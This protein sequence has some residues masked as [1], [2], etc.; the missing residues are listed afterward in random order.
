MR[1]NIFSKLLSLTYIISVIMLL[2][3]ISLKYVKADMITINTVENVRNDFTYYGLA[4]FYNNSEAYIVSSDR[5]DQLNDE[6]RTLTSD[7]SVA[8]IGHYKIMVIDGIVGEVSFSDDKLVW[9]TPSSIEIA[10]HPFQFKQRLLLKSDLR[11]E[12]ADLQRLRYVHM[13]SP[14]RVLCLGI[15]NVLSW[16]NSIHS[17][18]WGVSIILL[19]L[20]FK[21]F[22]LPANIHLTRT[23]RN[24]SKIQSSLAVELENIKATYDGEEAHSKFMSAHKQK[25]VTPFYSLKPLL[26]TLVP[27]PFLIAI[28]NVL[29]EL[30][31]LV[32]EPFLWISDLSRPDAV[33]QIDFHIPLLGSSINMLP[34]FMTL[35][36]V[37][38]ALL[39][40]NTIISAK[41]LKKQKL[42][43]YLM[44]FGFLVL[45]YPFPASMVLYWTC[46]NVWQIIQ[47]RFIKI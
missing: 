1:V 45:F 3:F 38:A 36:T 27:V 30:D 17:L 20:L 18:G 19:S 40:K 9:Q 46:A 5:V 32:G 22:I 43:L 12:S 28:F 24:V 37:C 25:G 7:Q 15:D 13:W 47:Q 33:Y 31:F 23:Q 8:I 39:H 44:A 14:L 34:I 10:E 2:S 35:L 11:H 21:I 41:E 16:L 42:N 6:V 4:S 29:G 26:L